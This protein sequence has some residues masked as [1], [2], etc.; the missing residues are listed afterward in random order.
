MIHNNDNNNVPTHKRVQYYDN[1]RVSI[2]SDRRRRITTVVVDV[3]SMCPSVY[4]NFF[5]QRA[6]TQTSNPHKHRRAAH[7][8]IL[9]IYKRI[10]IVRDP[11]VQYITIKIIIIRI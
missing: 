2:T 1:V 5:T 6:H 9:Y 4:I 7:C 11:P 3:V 10:Y 8:I